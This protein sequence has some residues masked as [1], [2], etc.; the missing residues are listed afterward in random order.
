M[1][2]ILIILVVIGVVL[3]LVS[4]IPMDATIK[5]IIYVLAILFVVIWLL[6]ALGL[7]AGFNL[8]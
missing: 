5:K 6:Q 4:L 1:I 3:Y 8:K 7:I 2:Q